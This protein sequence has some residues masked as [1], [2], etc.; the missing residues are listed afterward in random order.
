MFRTC[1]TSF[2]RVS[3]SN[4]HPNPINRINPNLNLTLTLTLPDHEEK[5][6]H[7]QAPCSELRDQPLLVQ[8]APITGPSW[9]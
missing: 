4:T 2:I 3:I 9:I 5:L 8:G 1:G 6:N 7:R